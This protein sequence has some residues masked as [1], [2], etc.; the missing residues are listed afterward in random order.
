MT[1]LP[2]LAS[3]ALF[4]LVASGAF[5]QSTPQTNP[6]RPSSTRA[7]PAAPAAQAAPA[8]EEAKGKRQRSP[9]QL[10]ND[11]RMRACGK[12]W[13]ENKAKLTQ[14]GQTWLKFSTECRARLKAAGQ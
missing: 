10:A 5:A 11:N 9:A 13:R 4:S 14:Q 12:E 1:F 7:A 6:L 8:A 2:R 3:V